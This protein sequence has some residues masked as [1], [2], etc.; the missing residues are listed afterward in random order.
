[1]TQVVEKE[2]GHSTPERARA[3]APTERS[4][5][6]LNTFQTLMR[7][8]REWHPYNAGQAMRIT[9]RPD[10]ERWRHAVTETIREVGLG[11]PKLSDKNRRVAFVEV[12]EVSV[13]R[14]ES[15]LANFTNSELNRPFA[16]NEL[17]IRFAVLTGALGEESEDSYL[18]VATY[19]HWIADSRA[20]R[21]LMHR[22]WERYRDARGESPLPA[23]TLRAPHFNRL[24][25]KYIG[26]LYRSRAI[27]QS[28]KSMYRHRRVYRTHLK[29]PAEFESHMIYTPLAGGVI[30]RVR[31]YA[32]SKGASVN[33]VFLAV[34]GQLM[35][36]H[37]AA[38]RI[39]T[40]K[41]K[42]FHYAR[43]QVGLGTIVDI[44]DHA[45]QPLDDVFG[46]Y[47]SSYTVVLKDPEKA[48]METLTKTITA[49]TA[50]IKKKNLAVKAYTALMAARLCWDSLG[51]FRR[52][53]LQPLVFQKNVPVQAGISNV[54]MTKSWV[55]APREAG[56]GPAVIDYL[57]ISPT[58]PL[59]P[60]V[61][62]LT[63]IG[64]RLSLCCTYRTTA[65]TAEKA[66][67]LVKRFIE[68]LSA[69]GTG[70]GGGA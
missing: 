12:D 47:L 26:L 62:T 4:P 69:I 8:W 14:H 57:R 16:G 18:L 28:L 42:L 7:R 59:I 39:R 56:E 67:D 9:G 70:A 11:I 58:G 15:D 68:R 44:R 5:L 19:D 41:K 13:E 35:G 49:T 50:K 20:M 45:R 34:L 25:R 61:F 48:D 10:M 22:I 37:T 53:R 40:R 52:K 3:K 51:K 46:L 33:D 21:E 32:K 55:D 64:D 38:E 23:L 43:D 65:F 30:D 2:T 17:P 27:Y 66:N 24:Y 6:R 1:V 63:T 29:D 54:N 60:L 36:E 31:A